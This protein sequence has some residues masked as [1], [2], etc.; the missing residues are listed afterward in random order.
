MQLFGPLPRAC[1]LFDGDERGAFEG[2]H[3][4]SRDMVV[5]EP[6]R[7]QFGHGRIFEVGKRFDVIAIEVILEHIVDDLALS[8]P[9]PIPKLHDD[10]VKGLIFYL[11]ELQVIL[12][13]L[14]QLQLVLHVHLKHLLE[15]ELVL[16]T[17]LQKLQALQDLPAAL[18]LS[19]DVELVV[20]DA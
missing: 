5:L 17:E 10:T 15:L 7:E 8:L 11:I 4:R 13:I 18:D 16:V 1:F 14:Q 12:A 20:L 9:I 2:D 19:Q 6:D 3:F